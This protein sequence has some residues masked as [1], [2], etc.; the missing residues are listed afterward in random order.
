MCIELNALQ[1]PTD[2]SVLL[3]GEKW[4]LPL[5]MSLEYE[6][7]DAF[8]LLGRKWALP[9]LL[10]ILSGTVRF[11]GL[12]RAV[13]GL[14]ARTLSQRLSEFQ[15]SGLIVKKNGNSGPWSER[16]ALTA[17][18]EEMRQLVQDLTSFSLKWR[19]R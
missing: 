12:L 17:K 8:R 4:S 7:D 9:I 11:N 2:E 5:F 14:N 19:R 3:R 13:P 16:Y 1:Y 10:E 6:T 18:G 15:M